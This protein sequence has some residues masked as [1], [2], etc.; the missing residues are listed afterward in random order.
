MPPPCMLTRA[1]AHAAG[2]IRCRPP[3]LALYLFF[4]KGE[5][6]DAV[7]ESHTSFTS[8]AAVTVLLVW[9]WGCRLTY[10]FVARGGIGHEDW[11]YTDQRKQFG[12]YYPLASIV[13][14]FYG[15]S[16]FMCCG[17]LS[18]YPAVLGGGAASTAWNMPQIIGA[19]LTAF[20][21]V[22][23]ASSDKQLDAFIAASKK[24]N[25]KGSGLASDD[26]PQ[27]LYH[28]VFR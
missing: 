7:H 24:G 22:L 16:T 6:A 10:N 19:A 11:R 5:A 23:E 17:T 9:V 12:A 21:I 8:P 1:Y 15:Q 4:K 26:S 20:A 2:I 28:F 3:L 13:T 27:P 14:V 18:L 25:A